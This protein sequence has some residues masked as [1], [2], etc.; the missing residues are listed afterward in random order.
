MYL[1]FMGCL[2][3]HSDLFSYISVVGNK[4]NFSCRAQVLC[5]QIN[6]IAIVPLHEDSTK[7]AFLRMVKYSSVY[8]LQEWKAYA[9][10]P[11]NWQRV[12]FRVGRHTKGVRE[13][14]ITVSCHIRSHQIM[15]SLKYLMWYNNIF[16]LIL[17]YPNNEN[18]HYQRVQWILN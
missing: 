14:S 12:R 2:N 18:L 3:L 11:P 4:R 6:L 5:L 17:V 16:Y 7:P 13:L 9:S 10:I 8:Y 1:L 15:N